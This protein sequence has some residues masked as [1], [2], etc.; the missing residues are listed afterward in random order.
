M[1]RAAVLDD[2]HVGGFR[3][4]LGYRFTRK[5]HV[6]KGGGWS[7]RCVYGFNFCFFGLK[8]GKMRCKMIYLAVK[9]KK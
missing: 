5:F 8:G 1:L 2:A 6:L 9:Q 3:G 7:W 4:P